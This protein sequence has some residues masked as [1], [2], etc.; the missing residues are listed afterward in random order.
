MHPQ[1]TGVAENI[2]Y[3]RY[4]TN[5]DALV[6]F[7]HGGVGGLYTYVTGK[8]HQ[9]QRKYY[10]SAESQAPMYKAFIK[11]IVSGDRCSVLAYDRRGCGNSRV[12]TGDE[13][14][15]YSMLDLC[16]D[17]ICLLRHHGW[18]SKRI[19]VIGTSAGG[20]IAM[21][22]AMRYPARVQS[23]ALLNTAA[24]LSKASKDIRY[25]K[26]NIY[27][28]IKD[29]PSSENQFYRDKNIDSRIRS[30]LLKKILDG[31]SD[32]VP[33][34]EGLSQNE[35]MEMIEQIS[36]KEMRD[37]VWKSQNRNI[38]VYFR[39]SAISKW[40]LRNIPTIII[41]G[42]LDTVIPYSAGIELYK[43]FKSE[44]VSFHTIEGFGHGVVESVECQRLVSKFL[45]EIG[46]M[47]ERV[48]GTNS[49][50]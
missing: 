9:R 5:E 36:V 47:E 29:S 31:N 43:I 39:D 4:G 11:E 19:H 12:R 27:L 28:K 32:Y 13:N 44:L 34:G 16:D 49:R 37:V 40:K 20:P 25:F 18:L 35:V 1:R 26:D 46:F 15:W 42:S 17:I 24:D 23:L 22:F 21:H 10:G 6:L 8:L 33:G 3:E 2:F 14:V 38:S 30:S 50:L 48:V 7:I 41:H 45:D